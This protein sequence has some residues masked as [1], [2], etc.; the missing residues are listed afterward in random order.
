MKEAKPMLE[1]DLDGN[2]EDVDL[3]ELMD[4]AVPETCACGWCTLA[5][6]VA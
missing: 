1:N 3:D 6:D 4:T 5:L 2:C